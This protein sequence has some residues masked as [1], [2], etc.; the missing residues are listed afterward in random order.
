MF[1]DSTVVNN[2]NKTFN[3]FDVS[4]NDRLLVGGTDL[5]GSDSFILFWD[6]RGQKMLGGYWESHSDDITQVCY[7]VCAKVFL[8]LSK[9]SVCITHCLLY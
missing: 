5:V 9:H 6:I 1:A 7:W 8:I 3:C 2:Q 4:S